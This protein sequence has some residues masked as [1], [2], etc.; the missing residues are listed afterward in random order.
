[1]FGN[2]LKNRVLSYSMVTLTE[3]DTKT[4]FTQCIHGTNSIDLELIVVVSSCL[5]FLTARLHVC[6]HPFE[7]HFSSRRQSWSPSHSSTQI[8]A[9]S[10]LRAGH[11][12]SWYSK[13]NNLQC[14][15]IYILYQLNHLLLEGVGWRVA[16]VTILPT[17]E[18]LLS[19]I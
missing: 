18:Q 1:M 7:Q 11:S 13:T 17:Y 10:S 16:E 19:W 15:K 2:D 6:P 9:S 5:P 8:P 4:A 14:Y 12:P 3:M